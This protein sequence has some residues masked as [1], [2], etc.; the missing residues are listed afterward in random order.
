MGQRIWIKGTTGSGKSTL[1][2]AVSE[3]LTIEQVELDD[4]WH[5]PGWQVRPLDEF[6]GLLEEKLSEP[7]WVISGNYSVATEIILPKTT[8]VVWLDYSRGTS[9]WRLFRRTVSRVWKR[10]PCCNG[11]YESLRRTLS[12]DSILVWH[13]KTYSKNRERM[14]AAAA[15]PKYRHCQQVVLRNPSETETWL[16]SLGNA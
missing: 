6:F 2:K 9:F 13:L 1:A 5:L 12:F 14:R 3:R 7:S 15:D 11:N 8:M 4:L 16:S 10:K